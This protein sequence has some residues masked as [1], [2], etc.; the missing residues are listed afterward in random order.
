MGSLLSKPITFNATSA[1]DLSA[2]AWRFV[3]FSAASTDA[4]K[5]VELCAAVEACGIVVTGAAIGR[6]MEIIPLN[7]QPAKITASAAISVGDRV[8]MTTDGKGLTTTT[9]TN[10]YYFVAMEAATADGDEIVGYTCNGMIA[11]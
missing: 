11:G 7:S 9:D 1:A 4:V 5:V 3:K 6:Q 2:Y 10:S 8:T